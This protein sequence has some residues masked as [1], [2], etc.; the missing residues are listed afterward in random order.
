[1]DKIS[2]LPHYGYNLANKRYDR[3]LKDL[4]D[5]INEII[6]KLEKEKEIKDM[7]PHELGRNALLWEINK[8]M[9]LLKEMKCDKYFKS[10]PIREVYEKYKDTFAGY[11]IS[12]QTYK[13]IWSAIQ[14]Y[15][16]EK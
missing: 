12:N 13:D 11:K 16:E 9:Q 5:K 15:C 2:K 10:D 1:M 14:R 8:N 3:I 4:W 6:A 7:S